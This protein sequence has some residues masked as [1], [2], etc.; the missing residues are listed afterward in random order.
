GAKRLPQ[1]V[2]IQYSIFNGHLIWL[3]GA[4][5]GPAHRAKGIAQR[6]SRWDGKITGQST[7]DEDMG[8]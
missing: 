2:N 3:R 1:F 5:N 6:A 4:G 8:T 7:T